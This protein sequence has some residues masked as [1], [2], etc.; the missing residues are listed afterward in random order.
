MFDTAIYLNVVFYGVVLTAR[1]T[2]VQAV[3]NG[4]EAHV[5]ND[6]VRWARPKFRRNRS[7]DQLKKNNDVQEPDIVQ[8]GGF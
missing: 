4:G 1:T 7:L 2:T 6:C 8:S 5:R 3:G